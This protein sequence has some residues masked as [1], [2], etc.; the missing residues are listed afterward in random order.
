[1]IKRKKIGQSLNRSPVYLI[2]RMKTFGITLYYFTYCDIEQVA[3][4]IP[5]R[6]SQMNR[7]HISHQC[8]TDNA[9]NINLMVIM[10]LSGV[11]FGL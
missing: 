11:Q 7:A 1:M 5:W 3:G 4:W 9:E 6:L 2:T 8:D 10:G